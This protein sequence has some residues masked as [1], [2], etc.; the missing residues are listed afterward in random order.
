MKKEVAQQIK[1]WAEGFKAKN[2]DTILEADDFARIAEA[3][4][5]RKAR[6]FN[7]EKGSVEQFTGMVCA[8]VEAEL[9]PQIIADTEFRRQCDSLDEPVGDDEGR[10]VGETLAESASDMR[11][12]WLRYDVRETIKGLKRKRDR[13]VLNAA[14]EGYTIREMAARR[15]MGPSSYYCAF[16]KP[17]AEAFRKS[18]E[19]LS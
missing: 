15:N 16:W 19:Q 8:N 9:A 6:Y 2:K 12:Y 11:R 4:W 3:R 17:A 10:T 5:E 18:F 13:Q 1:V 14:L 7:P